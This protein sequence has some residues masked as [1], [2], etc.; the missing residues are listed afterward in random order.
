MEVGLNFSGTDPYNSLH[1][2]FYF[3]FTCQCVNV[4]KLLTN[5][6]PSAISAMVSLRSW[7][8]IL[9]NRDFFSRS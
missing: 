4:L 2:S 7:V 8:K 5:E 1:C 3:I 9:L 6:K